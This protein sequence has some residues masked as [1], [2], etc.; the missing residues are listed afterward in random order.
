MYFEQEALIRKAELS[1]QP[2][3]QAWTASPG[4]PHRAA[5]PEQHSTLQ[6]VTG[7]NINDLTISSMAGLR[8]GAQEVQC[9]E[10]SYFIII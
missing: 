10:T 4:N 6:I 2:K 3:S 5:L 7:N 9:S 8:A 1:L